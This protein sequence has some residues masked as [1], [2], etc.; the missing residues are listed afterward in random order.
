MQLMAEMPQQQRY[1]FENKVYNTNYE[2]TDPVI[3]EYDAP[4]GK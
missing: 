3:T 2:Q 1:S 4:Q